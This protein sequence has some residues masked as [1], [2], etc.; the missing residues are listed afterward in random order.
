MGIRAEAASAAAA[1]VATVV[2]IVSLVL[3]AM[4]YATADSA[5]DRLNTQELEQY[6][7]KVMLREA[8]A[9]E[10]AQLGRGRSPS[11]WVVVNYSGA[12]AEKVWV[13]DNANTYYRIQGLEPCGYY[14]FDPGFTP[15]ELYFVDAVGRQWHR[16]YGQ[17]LIA[18]S[19]ELPPPNDKESNNGVLP[20]CLA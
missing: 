13:T 10:Y 12:Q 1:I 20:H 6:A 5:E 16:P 2:A 19:F 14:A 18:E 15:T 9:D 4:S 11:T 3:A 8:N 17:P 7:S